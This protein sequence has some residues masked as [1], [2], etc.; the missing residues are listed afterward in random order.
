MNYNPLLIIDFYKAV[1][2][3]Q[4]PKDITMIYTYSWTPL[5]KYKTYK[6]FLKIWLKKEID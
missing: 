4:Y 6:N 3:E 5:K 2:S 1:H